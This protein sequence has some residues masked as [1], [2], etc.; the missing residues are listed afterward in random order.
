MGT[1][2]NGRLAGRCVLITGAGGGLGRAT[3]LRFV[4]PD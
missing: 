1:D 4:L 2:I 3:A